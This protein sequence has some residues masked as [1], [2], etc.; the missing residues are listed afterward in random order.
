MKIFSFMRKPLKPILYGILLTLLCTVSLIFFLQYQSDKDTLNSW[1]NNYAYVGTIYPDVEWNALLTPLPEETKDLLTKASTITSLHSMQTYAAKL[2]DG[3]IIVDHMMSLDQLQQHFF[4]EAKVTH[5]MDWG[6]SFDFK[7]DRY[8]IELIKEWCSNKVGTRSLHVNLYRHA[9]EPAWEV[10]Q[11]VFFISGYIFDGN[12]VNVTEFELYT[13]TMWEMMMGQPPADVFG[14]NPYLL[15]GDGNDEQEILDFMEETGIA[16][17]YEKFTQLEGNLT[18]RAIEDFYALPKTATDRIYIT[19]GR[20]L[21]KED[22]GKKFCMISQNLANRN[23]YYLGDIVTLSIAEDSY[24]LYGWE[25]GYPLPEDDII[26]SY[27]PGEAYEIVGIYNQIG[28]DSFDP[29]YYSHTDIFIPSENEPALASLPYALSFR[30]SGLNYD[31]FIMET[32]PELEATGCAVR[33]TDTGWQD[34]EDAYY[35]M[36]L[37]SSVMFWCSV[38]TFLAAAIVFSLLLFFHLRMEYGLQRLMGAY[39]HEACQVY[40]AALTVIAL[41]AL[42]LSGIIGQVIAKSFLLSALLLP[43]ALLAAICFLLFLLLAMS[44]RGS[45]RNIIL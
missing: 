17:F 2:L 10:G 4:L 18:V 7:C 38:L 39:P 26:T 29:L 9:D 28:R 19:D 1:L 35:A 16:P 15:L 37:R 25:N 33:L 24:S 5:Y 23:R 44:E 43:L 20:A 30:V 13:P 27:T 8:T 45:V 14:Q 11:E 12:A 34:V 42:V 31:T 6:S 22:S 3:N 41:P 36:E 40:I 21:T 32:L